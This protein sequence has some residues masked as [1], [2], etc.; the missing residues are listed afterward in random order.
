MRLGVALDPLRT[1]RRLL[2][3]LAFVVKL[4]MRVLADG[5]KLMSVVTMATGLLLALLSVSYDDGT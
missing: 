1:G 2:F 5:R 4:V 3:H